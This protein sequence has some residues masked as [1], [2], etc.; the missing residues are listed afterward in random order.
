MLDAGWNSAQH[1]C[2][3]G[4]LKKIVSYAGLLAYREKNAMTNSRI[5]ADFNSVQF[6]LKIVYYFIQ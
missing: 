5:A 2:L 4:E 3:R 1:H 6:N